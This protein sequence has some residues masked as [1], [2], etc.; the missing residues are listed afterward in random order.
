[1]KTEE[2]FH[3]ESFIPSE[4]KK[5]VKIS[6]RV[7]IETYC[8]QEKMFYFKRLNVQDT[9][10]WVIFPHMGH[11]EVLLLGVTQQHMLT[12]RISLY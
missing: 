4:T 7:V 2:K 1:M 10:F 8:N 9:V 11:L 12:P 6:I 3:T 5:S